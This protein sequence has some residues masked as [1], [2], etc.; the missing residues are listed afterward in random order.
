MHSIK[1]PIA[2]L[3]VTES[4]KNNFLPRNFRNYMISVEHSVYNHMY[5]LSNDYVGGGWDY[6]DLANGGAY[7]APQGGESYRVAE[8]NNHASAKLSSDA[9]GILATL[10]ALNDLMCTLEED[11][12]IEKYQALRDFAMEHKEGPLI[13]HMID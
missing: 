5:R 8:Q 7:M 4:A 2:L 10:W 13:M 12:A 9:A 11:W 3:K 1:E 6:F